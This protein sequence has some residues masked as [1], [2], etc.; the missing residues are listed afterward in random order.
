MQ[1][2][3]YFS[4]KQVSEAAALVSVIKTSKMDGWRA[5]FL[6][7]LLVRSSFAGVFAQ[8]KGEQVFNL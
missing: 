7:F 5:R 6:D 8:A 4:H 3:K 2:F 1:G